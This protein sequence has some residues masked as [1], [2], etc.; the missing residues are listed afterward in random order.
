VPQLL[1]GASE[2]QVLEAFRDPHWRLG[3]LYSIRTRDGW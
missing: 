2:G 3:T 1:Q